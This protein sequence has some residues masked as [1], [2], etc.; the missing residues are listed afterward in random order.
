MEATNQKTMSDTIASLAAAL[1]KAQGQMRNASKDASN[2]HFRTKYA[3]LAS[4]MDAI[5]EPLSAN[6]LAIVQ[7]VSQ[8]ESSVGVRTL[9]LHSSGEW[10]SSELLVP[11]AQKTA[12]AVGSALSYARRYSISALCGVA[13]ADDDGEAA[14][15][16]SRRPERTPP[17]EERPRPAPQPVQPQAET[18]EP[19]PEEQPVPRALRAIR[20][21][22]SLA[23][24][25]ALTKL[26]VGLGVAKH[27]A[28]RN[29]Y[30]ERQKA[31]K[32]SAA[33]VA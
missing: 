9:L 22:E 8:Q 15:A 31:L 25:Q 24:L 2:P 12:Q 21:T 5:R 1:A 29:A 13:Q 14:T 3:D 4:V 19:V 20:E 17:Q 10:I 32:A 11:L 7:T 33:E 26:I 16:G 28:V 30:N 27:V 6:G 18:V 23:D